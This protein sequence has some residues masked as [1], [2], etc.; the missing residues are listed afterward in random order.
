MALQMSYPY[1]LLVT[2]VKVNGSSCSP[3]PTQR[4]ILQED[5]ETYNKDPA[6]PNNFY[7][8]ILNPEKDGSG[9]VVNWTLNLRNMSSPC[10]VVAAFKLPSPGTDPPPTG[11]YCKYSGGTITCGQTEASVVNDT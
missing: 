4:L 6:S 3:A 9:N 8:C 1:Y 10:A 7:A 11:N 2:I 5:N